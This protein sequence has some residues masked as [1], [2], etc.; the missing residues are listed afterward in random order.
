[1]QFPPARRILAP[2][3]ISVLLLVTS[4]GQT[5]APSRWDQA[6]QESTQKPG[7]AKQTKA[8]KSTAQNQNLP[9]KAVAG[10]KLNKYFPSSGGGFDRV[11]AQEKSGFAEAK[12]NKGGKNVAMLSINDIAGNPSAGAKFKQSTKKI[13]G[14]PAVSQGANITAV[15]VANRYQVKVQS[16]DPS[17]S[18]SDREAWL[19]KFNLGGL[20]SV[21]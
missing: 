19:S 18:A 4:C 1:M 10:G 15:L 21:K 6:Q 8:D 2:F 3:L 9:K 12:L 7:S 13:G 11:F 14:Y 5:Q 16:R 17:F 20:A